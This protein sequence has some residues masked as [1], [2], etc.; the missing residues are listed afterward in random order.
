MTSSKQEI[1][2]NLLIGRLVAIYKHNEKK[3]RL[4]FE[5]EADLMSSLLL[6]IHLGIT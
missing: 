1:K 6:S 4:S 5:D 2:T 3:R